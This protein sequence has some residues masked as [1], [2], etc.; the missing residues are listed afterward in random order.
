M[1]L[2]P[3]D[4]VFLGM[5]LQLIG[6]KPSRHLG[7]RTFG[8]PQPSAAPHL[9]TFDP[10][11]YRE[12]MVV[13]SLSVPQIWLMWTLLHDPGLRCHSRTSPTSWPFTWRRRASGDV[14]YA[15]KDVFVSH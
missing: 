7:F 4:D 13:H 1:E 5:C 3:I 11:F 2:F 10:C 14:D 9:Q 15:H 8:I 12:L 6:V